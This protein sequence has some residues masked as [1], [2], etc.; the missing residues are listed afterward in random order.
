MAWLRRD[1]AKAAAAEKQTADTAAAAP[2]GGKETSAKTE[3]NGTA[4]CVPFMSFLNFISIYLCVRYVYVFVICNFGFISRRR[5]GTRRL[6]FKVVVQDIAVVMR[7]PLSQLLCY[8]PFSKP[9]NQTMSLMY[10]IVI[11]ARAVT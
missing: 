10:V 2:S 11:H 4:T 6:G 5:L 9:I 8:E 3:T 1:A 7:L